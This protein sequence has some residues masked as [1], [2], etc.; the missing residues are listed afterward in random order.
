MEPQIVVF[1]GSFDPPHIGHINA[2][3]YILNN[4]CTINKVFVTPCVTHAFGKDLSDYDHRLNM[5]EIAFNLFNKELVQ[6]IDNPLKDKLEVDER[7][8]SIDLLK[9]L[10]ERY[11][12]DFHL[13]VGS[14]ICPEERVKW[15]CYQDLLCKFGFI[16]IPRG[17]EGSWIPDCSSTE[18]RK[19][20]SEGDFI[21][22]DKFLPVFVRDYIVEQKLYRK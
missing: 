3:Q 18:I 15:K 1:G 20:I 5:T 12:G 14:D 7:E 9:A 6:V 17:V 2:V 21:S 10:E 11:V 19:G 22:I 8:Y 16:D 13:A 4:W